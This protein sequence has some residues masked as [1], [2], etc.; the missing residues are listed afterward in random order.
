MD[1]SKL[2]KYLT[3]GFLSM[4]ALA[5]ITFSM[6]SFTNEENKVE[7][8]A[9]ETNMP[10][11]DRFVYL[12]PSDGW[13]LGD[14]RYA[15]W[16][17]GS[18]TGVA[19]AFVDMYWKD[20]DNGYDIYYA[21]IPADYTTINFVRMNGDTSENN[22]ENKWDQSDN[23]T[24][25]GRHIYYNNNFS[26]SEEYAN[27]YVA[28]STETVTID[29]SYDSSTINGDV[30]AYVYTTKKNVYNLPGIYVWPGVKVDAGDAVTFSDDY[31]MIIFNN[32]SD[33][34]ADLYVPAL[35]K[36]SQDKQD[37]VAQF[38]YNLTAYNNS[39]A[40][41]CGWWEINSDVFPSY[42]SEYARV[43]VKR[44]DTY[45]NHS[46]TSLHYYK[47]GVD[48]EVAEGGYIEFSSGDWQVYFN[49][50]IADLIGSQVQ[51]KIYDSRS[52][53]NSY[54]TTDSD[55][56]YSSGDN[57]QV[58]YANE[59]SSLTRGIID[60]PAPSS[61]SVILGGY[62]TCLESL[63]NGYGNFAQL[64]RT[65][66]TDDSGDFRIDDSW[67]NTIIKDFA[68]GDITYSGERNNTVKLIDKY[69]KMM[70]LYNQKVNES[71]ALIVAN[72][73]MID[74]NSF[75]I[76]IAVSLVAIASISFLVIRFK[77]RQN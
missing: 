2:I 59:D 18:S 6:V 9:E 77:K 15:I 19:D 35:I 28:P 70:N 65:W 20:N 57:A 31:D 75:I 34:T 58:Y 55:Y 48:A 23:I 62:F 37:G 52:G 74:Q 4:S 21:E 68:N 41:A 22:W 7:V 13:K 61:M 33:Q 67:Q 53:Y 17:F 11:F 39:S 14:E 25:T 72:S 63:D 1:K 36:E 50:K 27:A 16:C 54:S 49:V 5:A 51:V 46:I 38:T 40:T 71:S 42:T 66:L 43:Y 29:V 44:P 24:F 45:T 12:Q 60:N 30:Y 10:N 8:V 26:Y 47:E 32:G 69:N 64:S 76:L 73:P 56:T 3:V